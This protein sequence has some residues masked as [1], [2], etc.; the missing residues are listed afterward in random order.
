MPHFHRSNL[1]K[2]LASTTIVES[3]LGSVVQPSARNL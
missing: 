3:E 1:H 2:K